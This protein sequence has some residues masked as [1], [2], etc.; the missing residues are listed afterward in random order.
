MQARWLASLVALALGPAGAAAQ[1]PPDQPAQALFEDLLVNDPGTAPAVRDLLRSDAGFVGPQPT[2]AD[3]T[4]DRRMDAVV[5]VRIPG[6]AGTIAVYA[7][8]TDGTSTGRLR[9][10]LR[11]QA[12]YRATVRVAAGTVTVVLPRYADGDDLCCP[13]A[14]TER[15][16]AW[17]ARSHRLRRRA[18]V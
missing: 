5:Q 9:A 13:A 1:A 14:R 7:F 12:L 3:V 10:I 2:F 11:S 15:T 18:A 6:A 16:Y 4:G 17:D 8:S